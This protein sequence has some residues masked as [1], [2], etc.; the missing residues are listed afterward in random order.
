MRTD[1][2]TSTSRLTSTAVGTVAKVRAEFQRARRRFAARPAALQ[3]LIGVATLAALIALV[4]LAATGLPASSGS[5]VLLRAGR[6][7]SYDDLI[8]VTRA[9]DV[10]H[11][12]YRVDLHNRVEV[13]A[14][15]TTEANDA[16]A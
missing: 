14:D 6:K 15:Q 7:F 3:W 1:K 4:Y 13:A 9:L 12:E 2:P 5:Y 8:A 16:L 10:K 11:V